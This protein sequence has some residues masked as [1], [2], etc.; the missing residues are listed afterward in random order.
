MASRSQ[1][2]Q[3]L[4]GMFNAKYQGVFNK[5]SRDALQ[6]GIDTYLPGATL[7][8]VVPNFTTQLR[9]A[10]VTQAMEQGVPGA[11]PPTP[12]AAEQYKTDLQ[13]TDQAYQYAIEEG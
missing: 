13:V 8:E 9:S 12:E 4:A 7:D 2:I 6:K 11:A 3:M 5:E 1:I 10:T